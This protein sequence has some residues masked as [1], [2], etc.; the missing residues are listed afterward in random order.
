MKKQLSLLALAAAAACGAHAQQAGSSV[1]LYGIVDVGVVAIDGA[2]DKTH[3]FVSSGQQVG[4]RLGLRGTEEISPGWKAM[5]TMEHQFY[6]DTGS[7]NQQTPIS[8]TN[9]PDWV[10]NGVPLT[11]KGALAPTLGSTLNASLENRFWH[12][13]AW[14][15]LVTPVGGFVAGRQYSPAFATY[16]RFDPHMA[17]NV[18]NPL[19]LF[20]APTGIEVRIDNSVQWVVEQGG[21]RLNVMSG[22]GE[23]AIGNGRFT[24]ISAGYATGNFDIGIAFNQRKNSDG[25]TALENT[26]IGA[27]YTFGPHKLTGLYLKVKD[28]NSVLGPQLRASIG[29]SAPAPLRASFLAAGALIAKNLGWDGDLMYGG[30]HYQLSASNKLVV[31]YGRYD[32]AN[33]ARDMAVAGIALEHSLSKRTQVWLSGSRINNKTGSQVLP[34]AQGLYYGITDKPGRDSSAFSANLVHRF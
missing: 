32:D 24:G 5:F 18:G 11:I 8:G 28:E 16:G 1:S 27:S 3:R 33:N 15:G 30:V 21:L 4:S 26:I 17:G 29:A 20:A 19:T 2:S 34:F 7:Q 9:L 23:G 31:S 25:Q 6:A 12:R 13:Q 10:F 22:Q 14:V